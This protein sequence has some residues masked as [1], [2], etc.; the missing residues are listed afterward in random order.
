MCTAT[1][2]RHGRRAEVEPVRRRR[3]HPSRAAGT[4][5]L[6]G[7]RRAPWRR[8]RRIRTSSSCS[9]G[10]R[11]AAGTGHAHDDGRLPR[12]GDCTPDLGRRRLRPGSDEAR[13]GDDGDLRAAPRWRSTRARV[14][15]A[16]VDDTDGGLKSSPSGSVDF[17]RS[18]AGTGELQQRVLH[19]GGDAMLDKLVLPGRLPA[20]RGHW[21]RTRSTGAY[22][23]S[24]TAPATS[25]DD[26]DLAVTKRD[27]ETTVT[28][29]AAPRWRSTRARSARR[30]CG[31][32]GRRV[33][34]EP[35]RV[36]RLQPFGCGDGELQQRAS[37][38]LACPT[39]AD[40]LVLP[41]RLPADG[42]RRGAH[43]HGGVSGL[44][45]HA[46]DLDR[47]RHP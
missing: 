20:D 39:D 15:T 34:V 35:V 42:G 7:A 4:G 11:P 30:R 1:R 3:V 9:V 26:V 6:S 44:G 14:C 16:T 21:A 43:D 5:E 19:L 33:E 17:S 29:A 2:G 31:R 23:G 40:K 10:Y 25:D 8:W 13:H 45:L 24:A 47:Q 32:H 37:C 38:T 27:T 41:G 28:C 46:S 36:G 18:G 12:V 22:Q